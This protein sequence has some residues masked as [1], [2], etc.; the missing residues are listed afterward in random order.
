TAG[1]GLLAVIAFHV[2]TLFLDSLSWRALIPRQV[3]PSI[4]RLFHIHWIGDAVSAMLPVAQVGGEVVRVRLVSARGVPLPIATASVVVGLT[5]SV[6]TQ[7]PFTLSGLGVLIILTQDGHSL[8]GPLVLACTISLL[9][10]AG[11]YAVQR[12]GI[13]RI[14]ARIAA[15]VFSEK[16]GATS[17]IQRGEELDTAIRDCYTRKAAMVESALWTM[18]TWAS[19][20]V[21]VW[22]AL[23]ALGIPATYAHA[24]V[25]ESA[26]QAIR[27]AF[28]LVPGALGIQ[29]GGYLLIGRLLG[30][31]APNALAL[32]LIHRAR[33]LVFGIPGLFAWQVA[34]G[35]KLWGTKNNEPFPAPSTPASIP[36]SN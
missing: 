32:S 18:A 31:S 10:V 34:E 9:C 35:R 19:G 8:T 13:F 24:Y 14:I 23:H 21:E 25:L 30:I 36:T 15:H 33:E 20:A 3:R 29:E 22:I 4:W 27:S 16:D 5:L 12:I 26:G 17:F 11:F 28:F 2:V 6:A 7:I 1:W